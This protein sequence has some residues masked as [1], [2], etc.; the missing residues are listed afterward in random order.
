MLSNQLTNLVPGPCQEQP[1]VRKN[2][3][4]LND[5]WPVRSGKDLT[6]HT[7]GHCSIAVQIS[8]QFIWQLL[9]LLWD[10]PRALARSIWSP[11][12]CLLGLDERVCMLSMNVISQPDRP[13]KPGGERIKHVFHQANWRLTRGVVGGGLKTKPM[14]VLIKQKRTKKSCKT[15]APAHGDSG[16]T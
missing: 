15:W 7:R 16:S 14:F 8:Q 4:T 2:H 13:S 9:D 1:K 11:T 10:L 12:L 6:A 5:T 3:S